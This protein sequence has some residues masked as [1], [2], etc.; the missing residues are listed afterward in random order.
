MGL[1]SHQPGESDLITDTVKF[2]QK[3]FGPFKLDI[4]N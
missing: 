2:S 4:D 3:C 1:G